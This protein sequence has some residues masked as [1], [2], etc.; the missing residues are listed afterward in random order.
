MSIDHSSGTRALVAELLAQG[1]R[2]SEI[3]LRLG[4]SRATVSYHAKRL[5]VSGSPACGRRYDWAEIQRYYDAGHSISECQRH[6]GFARKAW[7]D[8]ARRGAVV[9]RPQATPLADML[10]HGSP[11]GRWNLKRRLIRSG[12][13]Q[14]VCEECGISDWR[15]RPLSL[16]LHHVNGIRDDNRLE[17]L[18]LLCPNC[19]S[20]TDNFGILNRRAATSP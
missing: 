10:V 9:A 7:A 14:P 13:K 15:G 16:A 19:H 11:H 17:N 8:A 6:F 3:A 5:G 20:Q 12:L 1:L 4:I 2:G 18:A